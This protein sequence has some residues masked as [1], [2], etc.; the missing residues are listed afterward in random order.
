MGLAE[1]V[2]AVGR[3]GDEGELD[4]EAAMGVNAHGH[5]VLLPLEAEDAGG[6]DHGR[7]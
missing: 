5:A 7:T 4:D 1:E 2:E 3:Q 6:D